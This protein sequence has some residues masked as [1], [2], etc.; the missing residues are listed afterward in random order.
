MLTSSEAYTAHDLYEMLQYAVDM[1]P[2]SQKKLFPFLS[3]EDDRGNPQVGH[4]DTCLPLFGMV[5]SAQ[6]LAPKLVV[7]GVPFD[8]VCKWN[9]SSKKVDVASP[10]SLAIRARHLLA[11]SAAHEMIRYFPLSIAEMY[12]FVSQI[13]EEQRACAVYACIASPPQ[14]SCNAKPRRRPDLFPIRDGMLT[15]V[16]DDQNSRLLSILTY[17]RSPKLVGAASAGAI[18]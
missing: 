5:Y 8:Y 2:D 17:T 3:P 9:D 4:Y 10:Q 14:Q 13:P 6:E 11:P 12:L 16:G 1:F 15:G 7:I 18:A